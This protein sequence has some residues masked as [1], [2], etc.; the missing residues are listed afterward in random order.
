MSWSRVRAGPSTDAVSGSVE[1]R[2]SALTAAKSGLFCAPPPPTS[3]SITLNKR[4]IRSR[5][6]IDFSRHILAKADGAVASRA[7]ED[8]LVTP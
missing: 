3:F 7:R 4:R 6:W 1:R 5:Y 2:S 8:L